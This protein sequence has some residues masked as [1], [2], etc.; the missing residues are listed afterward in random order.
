M[1][2]ASTQ[3]SVPP[4]SLPS[5][6]FGAASPG[7]SQN[8]PTPQT[9][10]A[11]HAQQ[12]ALVWQLARQK[13]STQD[14][15]SEQSRLVLQLGCAR[16]SGWQSPSAHMSC[17]PQSASLA[18][19]GWQVPLMHVSAAGAGQSAFRTHEPPVLG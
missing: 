17:G 15:P 8:P 19:A 9:V 2:T 16:S 14:C 18:H 10:A 13:P 1:Q 12:S 11:V 5:W 7:V 6:H 4:Q 3:E